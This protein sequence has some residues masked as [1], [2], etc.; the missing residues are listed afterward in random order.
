MDL[1]ASEML[2]PARHVRAALDSLRFGLDAV[3]TIAKEF[4]ASLE[5]SARRLV[6]LSDEPAL[7]IHFELRTKPSEPAGEPRLRVVSTLAHGIWPF[8]P[9]HKSVDGAHVLN[10][11]LTGGEVRCVSNIDALCGFPFGDVELHAR[12]YPF[13]DSEGVHHVRVLALARRSH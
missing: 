1:A 10:D 8:I 3:E 4:D 6:S 2:L 11:C 7:F 13:S 9:A 12:S 5:A